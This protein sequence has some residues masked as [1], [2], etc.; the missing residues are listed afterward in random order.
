MGRNIFDEKISCWSNTTRTSANNIT[1]SIRQFLDAGAAYLT[2]P[3]MPTDIQRLR[4]LYTT[5]MQTYPT[6]PSR[7][8]SLFDQYKQQK[9]YMPLATMG[10]VFKD[11][12]RIEDMQSASKVLCLD[13]DNTKPTDFYKYEG[14]EIPNH[15][16]KDWNQLKW[17]LSRLPF[18]AYAG[19]SIGGYGLFLLIPIENESL[20][21]EYWRCLQH[22]FSKHL[23]ITIDAQTKDITRPRFI[24]YDAQPYI[25][26]NAEIFRIKL[27]EQGTATQVR[28]FTLPRMARSS[29]EEAVR[30]CVDEIERRSLDIT[31]NYGDWIDIASALFNEF[32][33]AGMQ[34]FERISRF[35]PNANE[36]EINS[37]WKQNKNRSKVGIGT[38]FEICSRYG[39]RFRESTSEKRVQ[40]KGKQSPKSEDRIIYKRTPLFPEPESIWA[41]MTESEFNSI[42]TPDAVIQWQAAHQTAPF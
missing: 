34:Y 3:D 15:H 2:R 11:G 28:I 32:G 1:V 38:F 39:V 25:N 31:S 4:N 26:E 6:N 9:R 19:L 22:L 8:A 16:I 5:A 12:G 29:T 42:L 35:Y 7:A 36:R 23:N 21:S 14:K 33:E 27:R 37:K 10:G 40:P 30:K 41:D 24:S 13:I 17:Q 20:Y 18:V